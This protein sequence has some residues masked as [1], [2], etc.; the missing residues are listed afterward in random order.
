MSGLMQEMV[1]LYSFALV[2]YI[3][4]KCKV[5]NKNSHDVLSS[6]ILKITLPCLIIYSLD[7]PFEIG[8]LKEFIYLLLLSIYILTVSVVLA[9]WMGSRMKGGKKKRSSYESL[10]IFG[11][12]GFIGYA[13]V[14]TLF[15]EDGIIY[16]VIFNIFYLILIWTYGIYLFN[17]DSDA[18]TYK[19]LFNTGLISTLLGIILL[20]LPFSLPLLMTNMLGEIGYM[21]IPLSMIM[22]GSL[23]ATVKGKE[24]IA[25]MKNPYIWLAVLAKLILIPLLFFPFLFFLPCPQLFIIACVVSAMPSATSTSLY[26]QQFEGDVQFASV[27]VALSTMISLA[28][29][30]AFI[31]LLT[32]LLDN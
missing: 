13:V 24:L 14:Y 28:T 30:P 23:I 32:F 20:L 1:L 27:G 25:I 26:A 4:F 17:K 31:L 6:I 12:Q 11:N 5:L 15:G 16:V 7:K 18:F 29:I 2:G 3:V 21:T 9:S 8:M 10:I 19:K 22:I